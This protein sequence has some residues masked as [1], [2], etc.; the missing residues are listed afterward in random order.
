MLPLEWGRATDWSYEVPTGA[1]ACGNVRFLMRAFA[2]G[3]PMWKC[4][5]DGKPQIACLDIVLP[6]LYRPLGRQMGE[7]ERLEPDRAVRSHVQRPCT[8]AVAHGRLYAAQKGPT[9]GVHAS[10][11]W[12]LCKL[13]PKRWPRQAAFTGLCTSAGRPGL[14][15]TSGVLWHGCWLKSSRELLLS[16]GSVLLQ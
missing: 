16:P 4:A 10:A 5:Q 11:C 12:G 8:G 13:K 3:C 6:S 2:A 1:G 15:L 14:L 9:D 7:G